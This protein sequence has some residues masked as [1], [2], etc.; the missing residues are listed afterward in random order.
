MKSEVKIYFVVNYLDF[1]FRSKL[2]VK[3]SVRIYLMVKDEIRTCGILENHVENAGSHGGYEFR[4]IVLL[5][6]G[7]G[8][9]GF[10]RFMII[11]LFPALQSALNLN[12]QELG[13]VTGILSIT[14]GVASAVTGRISDKIGPRRVAAGALLIFSILVSFHG[15]AVGLGS[16]LLIRALMGLFEGAYTPAAIVATLEASDKSR[17]GRNIGLQQACLPL[18]GLAIAPIVVTQLLPILGWRGIFPVVTVPGIILAVLMWRTLR[19]PD[20]RA[21]EAQTVTHDVAPHRWREVFAYR[22]VLI[23]AAG[24]LCW[25][26]CLVVVSAMIP[27][28]LVDYL[29]IGTTQ[30]GFILSAIGFG[31][32]L[33]TFGLLSLSDRIGRKPVMIIGALGACFSLAF[34]KHAGPQPVLLFILLFL[35]HFFNNGLVV[36]TVGP[37]TTE[38]V[39]ARLMT[40]ASGLVIGVG[41]VF[42]GGVAPVIAGFTAQRFGI[43]HILDLALVGLAVGGVLILGLRET[44]SVVLSRRQ[45]QL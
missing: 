18:F 20:V 16:L 36:L 8:L 10:D 38:A 13:Y 41:E 3:V 15:F 30:M 34:L 14:W 7:F 32:S 43:Q 19:D 6:L 33:G 42:G 9:V 22:N 28:Y 2:D 24:M 45:T 4:A 1:C 11:P 35:T 26:I 31:A 29:H 37:L 5:A 21:L 44:A 39:P 17:H 27:S 12:Y 40:T 25:V 23:N